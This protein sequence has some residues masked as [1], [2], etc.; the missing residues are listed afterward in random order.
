MPKN[1]NHQNII[2]A[3]KRIP[4]GTVCSYGEVAAAAGLPGRARLVAKT[5]SDSSELNLPWHRVLRA[6][7]QIAFPTDSA[8]FNEQTQ[9]LRAEGVEVK[10]GRVKLKKKTLD[11]DA[12]LWAPD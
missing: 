8:M 9:R 5:L 2:N 7:G 12:L 6:S 1:S 10:L 3:I 4:Y 11:L